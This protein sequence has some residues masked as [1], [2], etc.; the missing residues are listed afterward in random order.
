MT[1][2]HA[3]SFHFSALSAPAAANQ[4][5]R[6]VRKGR[7]ASLRPR[8]PM[9]LRVAEGQAWVTLSQG[10][11]HQADGAVGAA[12]SGDLFLHAGQVLRVEAGQHVVVEPVGDRKLQYR[13]SAAPVRN[14]RP[15]P[16]WRRAAVGA[17]TTAPDPCGA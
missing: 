4:G 9:V 1:T 12:A 15:A 16:W 10:P 14:D 13:W 7:A 5:L 6:S 17:P 3:L 8:A 2:P 11:H